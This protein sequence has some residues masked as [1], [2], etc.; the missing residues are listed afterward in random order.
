MDVAILVILCSMFKNEYKMSNNGYSGMREDT[1]IIYSEKGKI[2]LIILNFSSIYKNGY[3]IYVDI[4]TGKKLS[5]IYY[6][7]VFI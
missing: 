4:K 6:W 3:R 7:L 1:E 5:P 2:L